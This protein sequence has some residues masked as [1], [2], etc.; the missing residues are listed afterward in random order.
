MGIE[1]EEVMAK[2]ESSEELSLDEQ[3]FSYR[4]QNE[5]LGA[6]MMESLSKYDLDCLYKLVGEVVDW[7]GTPLFYY[8]SLRAE[9]S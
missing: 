2:I 1:F 4:L 7:T 6:R 8:N 3:R 5:I 9:S